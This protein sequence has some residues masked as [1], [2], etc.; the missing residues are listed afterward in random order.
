MKMVLLFGTAVGHDLV[1]LNK[2]TLVH[3]QGVPW[4]GSDLHEDHL[5]SGTK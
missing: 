5:P 4:V 2:R 3:Q 1:V